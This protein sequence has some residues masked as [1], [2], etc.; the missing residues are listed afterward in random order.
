MAECRHPRPPGS[1]NRER[2]AD[3]Q[4][5]MYLMSVTTYLIKVHLLASHLSVPDRNRN[6]YGSSPI[7]LQHLRQFHHNY[8]LFGTQPETY[9]RYIFVIGKV[10]LGNEEYEEI[11]VRHFRVAYRRWSG[12]TVDSGRQA[13]LSP[14]DI[15]LP[16]GFDLAR[17]LHTASGQNPDPRSGYEQSYANPWFWDWRDRRTEAQTLLAYLKVP[18]R[19]C[20]SFEHSFSLD[21]HMANFHRLHRSCGVSP[22]CYMQRV[23]VLGE[24]ILDDEPSTVEAMISHTFLPHFAILYSQWSGIMVDWRVDAEIQPL[25]RTISV[26]FDVDMDN[27]WNRGGQGEAA[28]HFGSQQTENLNPPPPAPAPS[29]SLRGSDPL[30]AV[31]PRSTEAT[32]RATALQRPENI[33][34]R[35]H[36]LDAK[37]IEVCGLK[38]LNASLLASLLLQEDQKHDLYS[39]NTH[40]LQ[41]LAF[42]QQEKTFFGTDAKTYLNWVLGASNVELRN[43]MKERWLEVLEA[44]HDLDES[45]TEDDTS[46]DESYSEVLQPTSLRLIAAV[47][48]RRGG[49]KA[50]EGIVLAHPSAHPLFMSWDERNKEASHYRYKAYRIT[51]EFHLTNYDNLRKSCGLPV[52]EYLLR[53]FSHANVFQHLE[54]PGMHYDGYVNVGESG[55][56]CCSCKGLNDMNRTPKRE[57]LPLWRN[58]ESCIALAILRRSIA[59]G[60]VTRLHSMHR[61]TQG[62]DEDGCREAAAND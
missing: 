12:E 39:L 52:R 48:K 27:V 21:W 26:P 31:M 50:T 38:G 22:L 56:P 6:L 32:P 58:E 20:N 37:R 1:S 18:S 40:L 45:F 59:F 16:R 24:A 47:V 36:P 54:V 30:A 60:A 14:T 34:A 61:D 41:H 55:K 8:R 13:L 11:A 4:K 19:M 2:L 17:E 10:S 29:S 57:A 43:D 28:M 23:L 53:V 7:V 35:W 5:A 49:E 46:D 51:L 9:L 33:L 3:D 15:V 62:V 42:Y 25:I 44:S